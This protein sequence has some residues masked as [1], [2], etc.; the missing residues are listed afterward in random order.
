MPAGSAILWHG[1]TWHGSFPRKKPGL[2]INLSAYFCRPH[3]MPQESYRDSIPE[4]FLDGEDP[5]ALQREF[6]TIQ[7]LIELLH[8]ERQS[9]RRATPN[10]SPPPL[11]VRV[12]VGT[13]SA[14]ILGWL[15]FE[16][17]LLAATGLA[18]HDRAEVRQQ[19]VQMLQSMVERTL[20][21]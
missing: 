5:R 21:V 1:A 17:Y 13:L 14:L 16:P 15:V 11:E 7:R 4:G 18:E 9:L 3:L 6:P 12:G 19:V 2:R 20:T 8:S 10:S